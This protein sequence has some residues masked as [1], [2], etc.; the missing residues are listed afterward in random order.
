MAPGINDA[1]ELIRME[2]ELHTAIDEE[3]FSL[4]FQPIMNL[5][6]RHDAGD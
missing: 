5:P 4:D 2:S 6:E 1:V 3:Q